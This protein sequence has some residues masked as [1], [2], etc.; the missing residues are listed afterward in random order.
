MGVKSGVV[1]EG[2]LNRE[3]TISSRLFLVLRSGVLGVLLFGT[4]VDG[5]LVLGSAG[6]GFLQAL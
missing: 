6:N 5:D 2:G 3:K 1:G 4:Q